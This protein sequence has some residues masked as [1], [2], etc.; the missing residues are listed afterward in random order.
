MCELL[1][2]W[3]HHHSWRTPDTYR[4]LGWRLLSIWLDFTIMAV[5]YCRCIS[6]LL[7][8]LFPTHFLLPGLTFLLV[9]DEML[10]KNTDIQGLGLWILLVLWLQREGGGGGGGGAGG[11]GSRLEASKTESSVGGR[12][13]SEGARPLC[14]VC[15]ELTTQTYVLR[16]CTHTAEDSLI[17]PEYLD[18]FSL[19]ISCQHKS[20]SAGSE[21][22]S[23][24]FPYVSFVEDK[25]T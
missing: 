19:G 8:S 11:C 22:Q 9:L 6:L 17:A 13:R 21:Y 16:M 3:A 10:H 2:D 14:W 23:C 5:L 25:N 4:N 24:S 7:D 20:H 12:Q 15:T 1:V 18:L